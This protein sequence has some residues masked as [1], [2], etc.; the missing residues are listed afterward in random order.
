MLI[1]AILRL[2]RSFAKPYRPLLTH[3]KSNNN[4]L[5]LCSVVTD[6]PGFSGA[7]AR[8]SCIVRRLMLMHA[9]HRSGPR[10]GSH[11]MRR[12]L[13]Y[14]LRTDDSRLARA[15]SGGDQHDSRHHSCFLSI[16]QP[17]K[18]RSSNRR[19]LVNRDHEHRAADQP[20]ALCDGARRP[21]PR[22]QSRPVADR[23]SAQAT[24]PS[25]PELSSSAGQHSASIAG[26]DLDRHDGIALYGRAP[27]G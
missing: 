9:R 7:C 13:T 14:T 25:L 24:S 23:R 2:Y 22:A 12:D 26:I 18:R 20:A 6:V 1:H 8:I 16:E 27:R 11:L 10:P 3:F 4:F 15:D 19:A 21:D 5:T 17:A